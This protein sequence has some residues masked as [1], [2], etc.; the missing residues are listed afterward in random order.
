MCDERP[1]A[2]MI[3]KI[4]FLWL[5]LLF[6]FSPCAMG[7]YGEANRGGGFLWGGD[8]LYLYFFQEK[9]FGVKVLDEGNSQEKKK[10]GGHVKAFEASKCVAGINGSYFTKENN[11]LGMV[12][13][14]GK[15]LHV[16]ETGSF[17]VAGLLC[18]NGK[19]LELIRSKDYLKWSG[20]KKKAV[21]EALQGGPFLVEKG[22]KIKGL[23]NKKP[24][25]RTFVATDGKGKWCIGVSSSL[26]LDALA[27]WLADTK[28]LGSFKVQ[29][30]L[31]LDGGSSSLFWLK[32]KNSLMSP[33]KPVRNYLGVAPR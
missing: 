25:A 11:P 21:K 18:D 30:A 20:E 4:G 3:K 15:R 28:T 7:Q 23:D 16:L 22:K 6:V 2:C 5:L 19:K 26:T 9:D 33:I 10:Y 14:E 31:N 24:A 27:G 32:E 13:Q 1:V 17:A 12:I 29:T 8:K